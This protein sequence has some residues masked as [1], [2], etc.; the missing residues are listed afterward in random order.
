MKQRHT[1]LS[2]AY[3]PSIQYFQ[4]LL[5]YKYVYIELNENY[6]R[7]TSSNRTKIL[8][9]NGVILLSV[10][11]KKKSSKTTIKNI[12]IANESWK[13]KH[14]HSIQSAYGSSPFF[15]HYFDNLKKIINNNHEYLIDLNNE[16]LNYFIHE[17]NITK[18]IHYTDRYYQ[19][20]SSLFLDQRNEKKK[21]K[22]KAYQQVF[23]TKYIIN[24]SIIDLMFNLGPNAKEHI[25]PTIG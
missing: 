3:L 15:I 24:L 14:I 21:Y 5:D 6:K 16:I 7:H 1:I 25:S 12:K 19:K 8:G 18:K 23:G 4:S 22:Q 2:T 9:A 17:M 13:K 11:I 10:P 20:Y